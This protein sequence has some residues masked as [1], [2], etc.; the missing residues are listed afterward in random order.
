M[1]PSS[2]SARA[3]Q[4]AWTAFLLQV[5]GKSLARI[6]RVPFSVVFTL[7]PV[8]TERSALLLPAH[9][10]KAMVLTGLLFKPILP[11]PQVVVPK[12]AAD[13][14]TILRVALVFLGMLWFRLRS[15]QVQVTSVLVTV[16]LKVLLV[17]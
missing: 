1:P 8:S 6:L 17:T 5:L 14:L 12:G 13:L 2:T 16:V 9:W 3:I 10:G 7:L 15:V 11:V 4:R